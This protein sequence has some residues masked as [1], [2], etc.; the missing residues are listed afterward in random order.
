MSLIN[1]IYY[2]IFGSPHAR[3]VKSL[4]PTLRAIH[5]ARE[6]LKALDDSELQ[7]KTE[8]F[9]QE[10]SSGKTLDDI[11]PDAFAVCQEACDRRL[12]I[13]NA[14]RAEHE[15][16]VSKLSSE[17]QQVLQNSRNE[18]E[19]GKPE[20]EILLPGAFYQRVREI[21]PESVKPFR[22]ESFEVQL[23]GG[24]V[25][26]E[27]RIAEMQT[28][29]GKTLA[30]S[31]PVYLNALG[32]QGVH[33]ITVNDY[34]AGRD[35]EMMGKAYKFLGLNV[36]LIVH[37][38]TQEQRRESYNAD[39]TY[40][41][42]NE[43]GFDYL[44]DNMATD[45]EGV[46]QRDLNFCIVDEVDSVL[47]DEARTPLIIS[48]P[49]EQSTD[50]YKKA[51]GIIPRL[52]KGT[53][54]TV[55]EKNHNVTLNDSGVQACENLLGVDN[56]YGD[57][58]A[59]WIH[60]ID[61]ALKAH[62]LYQKDVD[63]IVKDQEVVIVDENT[64]R[65]MEGRRY[66][67]GL[68]QALEAKE[69]VKI[70][71][72]NQ[73]LATITFQNFFRMYNKLAGMTGTADTEAEEFEKI[74]NL[75]VTVIPTNRPCIR[76]DADDLVYRT[77]KEKFDAIV[78]DI[79]QRHQNGQP[80]LVGT[81]SVE[82]SE[83]VATLL[84]RRGVK[85]EVLNAKNH[86]REAEIIA[87][88]GHKGRVTI[89]TNMAGRG[90]DIALGPGVKE[91]G[92]LHVLGTERHEARRI[93]NQLRGRSGRQG[94]PGSSQY[95]LSLQDTLM[96]LFGGARI[97]GLM[98]RLKMEEGEVISAGLV[99]RAIAGAQKRVEGQNFEA[100]KHLLQYDDVMNEQRK[101]VY[102]L[103]LR[104][105]KGENLKDE[106]S[107]RLEEA[108]DIKVSQFINPGSFQEDWDLDGLKTELQ[109]SFGIETS[110]GDA[111]SLD[112]DSVLDDIIEKCKERYSRL[113][114]IVPE[115]EVRNL[116]RRILLLTIDQHWKDHLYAMDHLRD[117][118]RFQGYAQ[119]D[120]L[121]IYKKEGFSMFESCMDN[122]SLVTVQRLLNMRLQIGERAVPLDE[123]VPR[124]QAVPTTENT[125]EIK[126][127]ST[128]P[129]G[130]AAQGAPAQQKPPAG[131]PAPVKRESPKVGR[132]E[133]CWCGSGKK[134]KQC[135]GKRS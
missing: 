116:E 13:F 75:P 48:G 86:G 62:S 55:D 101:V 3:K 37:G 73:T 74:Y 107:G 76:D 38:L 31:C 110:F 67:D 64:G 71:R 58:N 61:Q 59:E 9:K 89:A 28:G 72:E 78:E 128:A 68:H 85:H 115:E 100:R 122:I 41:T 15:F 120:P 87:F 132:N 32:G 103:R 51:N 17:L 109:R 34:L 43:F 118:I 96:R 111:A 40:G 83:V 82:K 95:Y 54:Y 121:M 127:I 93:D 2:K 119:K 125:S 14:L 16:D 7:K 114:N 81:V 69:N 56:L 21:Y 80:V 131:K 77:E 39:V 135:H 12:G 123:L 129:G 20:H 46:V 124:Q 94:D 70:M 23:I 106:I 113:E 10:L 63:Y 108:V 105:L 112:A 24:I 11:L 91:L 88:A 126:S 8:E 19:S 22:M 5:E 4:Q 79:Y 6:P 92:G 117:S 45:I 52:K 50:K 53:D 60:F 26:H 33:V 18:L 1:S 97:Q 98:T 42:N 47:I 30:A 84:K 35:A 65:L 90:T 36:G 102:A 49:A 104:A 134:Y 133:P 130:P 25:L 99:N 44:R 57:L 27:G 29:E 66:S